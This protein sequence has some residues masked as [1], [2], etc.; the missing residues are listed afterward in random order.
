MR[1]FFLS[2]S[3]HSAQAPVPSPNALT[4]VACACA[5]K[6]VEEKN[7]PIQSVAFWSSQTTL[8]SSLRRREPH[9]LQTRMA[10]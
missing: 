7:S 6:F 5:M 9:S 10:G 3:T 8:T 1:A 4:T 2:R